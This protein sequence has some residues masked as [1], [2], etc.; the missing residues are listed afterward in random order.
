M[1]VG[2]MYLMLHG[3]NSR[4]RKIQIEALPSV[5]EESTEGAVRTHGIYVTSTLAA[6]PYERITAQGLGVKSAV[7]VIVRA[8]GVLLLRQGAA[9]L[10]IP[11]TLLQR[12][13]VTSGMIGKFA[14]PGSIVVLRW[15]LDALALDTGI[16]IRSDEARAALIEQ[17][18]EL[19]DSRHGPK[20]EH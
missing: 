9:D 10:F 5:P 4:T 18:T 19:I 17:I 6:Q 20:V 2:I 16:H 13:G 8:D 1:T 3:W 12:V 11:L 7:E 14:A 15:T